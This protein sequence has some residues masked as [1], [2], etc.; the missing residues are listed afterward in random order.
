M[1]FEQHGDAMAAHRFFGQGTTALGHQVA[2]LQTD[3]LLVQAGIADD[4]GRDLGFVGFDN[5]HAV[6][7]KVLASQVKGVAVDNPLDH[8]RIQEAQPFC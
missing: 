2:I 8:R 6:F 5:P 1:I 4:G 3:G 7:S